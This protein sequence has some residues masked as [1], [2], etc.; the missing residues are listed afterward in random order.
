MVE[1]ELGLFLRTRREAVT[2]AD[3]GLPAGSRRRAR[4]LRRS[5]VAALADVSVE[6]VT[7]LEQG[8]DRRPSPQV[9]ASLAD[10]LRLTAGERVHLYRLTKA[11]D[12]SFN[13]RGEADPVRTVR[14]AVRALLERLEPTPAVLLNQLT[15]VL[16]HTEGYERIAGPAGLLDQPQPNLVRFVF[17]DERARTV[18][19]DWDRVA[20][21]LVA[22]LKQG[23][24][25]AERHMA[26]LA[27]EIAFRA[28]DDFVRRVQTVASLAKPNG[29]LRFAARGEGV[30]RLS[31]EMLELSADDDQRMIVYLPADAATSA[32]LD[33]INSRHG[34]PRHLAAV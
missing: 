24:F 21:E 31:Y 15:D 7:R 14:P 16:A 19:P 26:A 5:E 18:Y 33:R 8:R 30:L 11:A 2:P 22:G 29:V 25:R 23:P 10:A 12:P 6:Y 1:N 20:D 28:G 27:D 9:L 17:T 3:V 34:R 13:C 32:A 4:G